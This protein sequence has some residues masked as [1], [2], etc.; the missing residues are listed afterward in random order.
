MATTWL[1]PALAELRAAAGPL[2][3]RCLAD[4]A[5]WPA[6]RWDEPTFC[7]GWDARAVVVHLIQGAERHHDAVTRGLQG[8]ATSPGGRSGAE[9]AAARRA[10]AVQLRELDRATLVAR[11]RERVAA[12]VSA[13][14]AIEGSDPGLLAWHYSGLQPLPW[15]ATQW[16]TELMIHDWDIR[17][18][19]DPATEVDAATANALAPNLID[20]V[21]IWF[22]QPANADLAGRVG[23]RLTATPPAAADLVLANG[24]LTIEAAGPADAVVTTDPAALA[25]VQTFRRPFAFYADR[26]RWSIGG[27]HRLGERFSGGFRAI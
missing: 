16:L 15:W 1:I 20:R 4:L 13:F 11:L 23:L 8:D 22:D 19:R 25:L 9:V 6:E 7:P 26:D 12:L 24:V 21:A 5:A 3:A 27:D 10:E 17:Q 18:P 14:A 2:E